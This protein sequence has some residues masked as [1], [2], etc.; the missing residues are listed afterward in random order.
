MLLIFNDNGSGKDK[1]DVN[2]KRATNS[3][4]L[5]EIRN[6]PTYIK[7]NRLLCKIN[8]YRYETDVHHCK[9]KSH[10]LN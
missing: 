2:A 7:I 4:K 3:E 6:R 9:T 10:S 5:S 1:N 8:K